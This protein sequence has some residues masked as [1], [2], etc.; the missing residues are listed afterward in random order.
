MSEN[1]EIEYKSMV[2]SVD[3]SRL[4]HHF[5]VKPE[6]FFIQ[7]NIY[8][9]SADG[10]LKKHRFGLRIRLFDT[11]AELTL[12]VPQPEGLLEVTDH[13]TRAQA[14]QILTADSLP[15]HSHVSDYLKKCAI[16]PNDLHQIGSLKTRRAQKQISQGLLALDESWYGQ[17]HDF[18]IELEVSDAAQGK[19]DFTQMLRDLSV[20]LVPAENKILR[21]LSEFNN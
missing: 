16:E 21:M 8:F 18:E 17:S 9:D 4:I 6:D 12:K 14:E 11:S 3:F 1:L 15:L 7:E 20:P 10:I 2:N 13:L 5:D 19:L